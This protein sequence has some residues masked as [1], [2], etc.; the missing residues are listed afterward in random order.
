[1]RAL[2][3]LDIDPAFPAFIRYCQWLNA[4]VTIISDGIDYFIRRILKRYHLSH[5][6]IIANHLQRTPE[7][8]WRM[9]TP[10]SAAGCTAAAGVCK[11]A[12]VADSTFSVFIGDGRSDFCA[13]NKVDLLFAKSTLA[14]YCE[15][16]GIDYTA[17]H[18]FADIQRALP[19]L[20]PMPHE[21][22]AKAEAHAVA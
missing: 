17:Y 7:G 13:S 8:A 19:H 6:P 10:Y 9:A 22:Y 1:M 2:D 21:H 20:L 3:S 14:T 15:Q 11:C 4:P 5:L 16:Q 18:S 12:K